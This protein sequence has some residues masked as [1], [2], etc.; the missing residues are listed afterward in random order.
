MNALK[1]C[2]VTKSKIQETRQIISELPKNTLISLESLVGWNPAT[3]RESLNRNLKLFG[4]D[5]TIMITLRSPVEYMTSVYVQMLHQGNLVPPEKFF[6]SDSDYIYIEN[7]VRPGLCEIFK[8]DDLDYKFLLK[9]YG[10]SFSKVL[11]VPVQSIAGFEYFDELF[12]EY[13]MDSGLKNDLINTFNGSKRENRAYSD[14]AVK[15]TFFRKQILKIFDLRPSNSFDHI[16][17]NYAKKIETNFEEISN[18]KFSRKRLTKKIALSLV[19]I[20]RWRF[21]MQNIVNKILPYKRFELPKSTYLGRNIEKNK[22]IYENLL[23]SEKKY[24]IYSK[25]D[26]N[27][28]S[29]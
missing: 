23:L 25:D 18:V 17:D 26:L 3:W 24:Y 29:E 11:A 9:V 1:E 4:S 5:T 20:F 16:F 6:L 2:V 28:E 14:L 22:E 27:D 19:R 15:M 13:S 12:P 10:E 21:L 7:L 8:V